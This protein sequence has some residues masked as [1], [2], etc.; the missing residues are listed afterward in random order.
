MFFSR[1]AT[2]SSSST[3]PS[4]TCAHR[5]GGPGDGA[6]AIAPATGIGGARG[7]G[8]GIARHEAADGVRDPSPALL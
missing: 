3:H 4:T 5:Q 2:N 6:R 1:T 8:N 7:F